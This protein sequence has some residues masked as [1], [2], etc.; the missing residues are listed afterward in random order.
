MANFFPQLI[1]GAIA[2]YPIRKTIATRT[3]RN[4]LPDG[5]LYLNSDP[6]AGHIL[7][8][9][10]Y[11]GLSTQ[12]IGSLTAHFDACR[13]RFQAFTFIDP[14]D[15]MLINS[16]NLAAAPWL[17]S[18]GL[19]LSGNA[20]D[21]L[22]K[23]GAF[24]LTNNAQVAAQLS[25]TSNVPANYQYCF[26]AY[27]M[28][29]E[30]TTVELV[31]SGPASEERTAV[32]AGPEWNRVVSNGS[33]SDMGTEFTVAISLLPGQ[34]ISVY[35]PQLEAQVAPSRYRA[36]FTRAGVY[37]NAHWAVDALPVMADAPNLFSTIFTIEAPI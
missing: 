1:S 33:L 27:V 28:S 6:A 26:S 34:R 24:V 3:I 23:S 32:T 20:A 11:Q 37:P 2:Q 13:G 22:G 12:E 29:A 16:A 9:L 30:P 21:P 7:W 5:S 19:N 17:P 8:Q 35:G 4:V 31:R 15:N 36:T 18:T 25:Q 14:T 10:A